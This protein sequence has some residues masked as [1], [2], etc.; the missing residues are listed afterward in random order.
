MK[1]EKDKINR[2]LK[3]ARGQI[4][5]RLRMVVED[6]YCIDLSNQLLVTGVV[7]RTANREV[8]RAHMH[9]CLEGALEEGNAD[10]R[11]A[12]VMKIIDKLSR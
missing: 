6:R 4:D 9:G 1:A 2:L 11:P 10:E 12:E 3:T 5:G 8:L 7:L